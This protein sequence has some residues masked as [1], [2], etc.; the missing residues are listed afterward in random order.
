[1]S[2]NLALDWVMMA[3]SL[4]NTVLLVWLG[5]TVLFNSDRRTWG[6][7]LAS[8]GL[9]LGGAFFV[10]HT[11][12][13]GQGLIQLGWWSMIFW[14]T[15][16]LAPAIVLPFAWYVVTL[17]YA[18][19]WEAPAS[20]LQRRQR[21]WFV[22]VLC[23]LSMGL[24]GLGVGV[25]LLS[26]PAPEFANLR[27]FIRWSIAGIPLLALGYSG[28]VILCIGLSLDALRR[29][30]P[31]ARVM[32]AAARQRA[33]PWLVGAAL[34]LLLVSLLVAGVMLWVVQ[35]AQRLSFYD[36]VLTARRTIAWV[37]LL[38][39]GIISQAILFLGQAI[40]SYEIFT[41]RSLPRRG[42]QRHWR[43]AIIL[44]AGYGLIGGGAAV[45]QWH[46][47][48]P[49]LL[50]TL[51]MTLFF[52]LFSW[53]S[54]AERERYIDYLRPFVASQG[55][56]DQLLTETTSPVVDTTTPFHTL[57]ADVLGA[58]VAYLVA[59]GPLAP[60]AG[61]PLAYPSAMAATAPV[62]DF[63]ARQFTTPDS[64]S[65]AVDPQ[66]YGG[67]IWAVPLWSQRGLIG[68]FL[69]GEK[70]NAGLYTQE[71]I[72]I[73]RIS[74][75]RL[76]DTQASAEMARRLMLLQRQRLAQS[77]LIDQQTRRVLHDEIL[78]GLQTAL[79]TLSAA[80]AGDA[81]TSAITQL[82]QTHRQIADL[83]H[84]MPTTTAPEVTRLGLLPA[85]QRLTERE[86]AHAFDEV[87]W[88]VTS[89]AAQRLAGIPPLTAEV[90]YYAAREA[91]RNAAVHGRG[92]RPLHLTITLCHTNGLQLQIE[93]NGVGLTNQPNADQFQRRAEAGSGQGLAL[94][95]T[96]M[97][98]IG[99]A[100]AIESA[101]NAYTRVSLTLP[102]N[103]LP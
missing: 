64:S 53:R 33:R 31:S 67:A 63:L 41:G 94:H 83:L 101:P 58:K 19:F 66:N 95:S 40:V 16:G 73:A 3:V 18:G 90:V 42:L 45:I 80:P 4:F 30:G 28:Y 56:Y 93:D 32:G 46:P 15:V 69:L 44:A 91:M 52:A 81:V 78:P 50:T 48:Y 14:W 98:V 76:I 74:G 60:L 21:H 71:E 24:A 27:L 87:T 68:V 43:R 85:L 72:E 51:L 49:L 70:Q 47:V 38:I 89:A 39:A 86:F 88:Q 5:L 75:E 8:G 26:V 11:A 62:V 29:P 20:G 17:W 84:A 7:W 59:W 36:F 99:G 25:F 100:L 13:L 103:A 34:A 65:V 97:A 22:L 54:Y 92:D 79:I 61:P 102:E 6:I 1:M 2:G 12:I 55:L 57:C 82:S 9:L 96:M 77:Q 35:S 37:D 10:S 23:L